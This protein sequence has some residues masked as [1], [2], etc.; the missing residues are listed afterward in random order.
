MTAPVDAHVLPLPICSAEGQL[1]IV[2]FPFRNISRYAN[3]LA[4]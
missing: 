3:L 2:R 4:V 1:D